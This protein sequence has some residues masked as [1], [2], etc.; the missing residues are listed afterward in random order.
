MWEKC[1]AKIHS[2]F[3]LKNAPQLDRIV[4]IDSDQIKILLFKIIWCKRQPTYLKDP[5]Q[6]S[7]ICIKLIMAVTLLCGF[8]IS[9]KR[10]NYFFFTTT[11]SVSFY[12]FILYFSCSSFVTVL[13]SFAI[14]YLTL[15]FFFHYCTYIFFIIF[16]SLHFLRLYPFSFLFLKFMTLSIY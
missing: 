13:F 5:N 14:F 3:F 15:S 1:F 6:V 11:T 4:K 12:H 10:T 8:H 9:K 16:V 2:V 7:E